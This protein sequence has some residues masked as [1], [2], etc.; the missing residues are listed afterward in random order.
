LKPLKF[1]GLIYDG[2]NDRLY[3]ET[4]KGKTLEIPKNKV[5]SMVRSW[6]LWSSEGEPR[7][8]NT[9][10]ELMISRISGFI[11]ACLYNGTINLSDYWDRWE[12]SSRRGSWQK[13][14][15]AE[16]IFKKKGIKPNLYNSSSVACKWF[17]NKK[18]PQYT[19][20]KR[21]VIYL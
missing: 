18:L 11:Q 21:K 12:I 1:C 8:N 5:K 3:S 10:Y 14:R 17:M 19:N 13:S 2:W 4:R 7:K 20:A 15:S 9:W 16:R 6:E